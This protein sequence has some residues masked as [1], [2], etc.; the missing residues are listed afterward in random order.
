MEWAEI[1]E[2]EPARKELGR[3]YFKGWM[4]PSDQHHLMLNQLAALSG[5][6]LW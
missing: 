1:S 3:D 5:P 6:I 2:L 4:M